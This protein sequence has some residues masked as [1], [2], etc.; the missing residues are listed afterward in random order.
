[1]DLDEYDE[2]IEIGAIR[3]NLTNMDLDRKFWS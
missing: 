1:M 3:L 2:I